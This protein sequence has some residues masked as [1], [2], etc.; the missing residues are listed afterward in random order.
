VLSAEKS[1]QCPGNFV[2]LLLEALKNII[3]KKK[4]KQKKKQKK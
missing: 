4:N 1:P 3:T 2:E